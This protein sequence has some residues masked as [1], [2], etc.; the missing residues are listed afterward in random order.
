MYPL[1]PH[2]FSHTDLMPRV[3]RVHVRTFLMDR[4]RF[5][6]S[7]VTDCFWPTCDGRLSE[8]RTPNRPVRTWS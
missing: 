6:T 7:H 1:N 5:A 8:M 2:R 3:L 4:F